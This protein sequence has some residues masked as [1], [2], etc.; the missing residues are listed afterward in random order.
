ME[1]KHIIIV[2]IIAIIL[3]VL[4]LTVIQDQAGVAVINTELNVSDSNNSS[5]TLNYMLASGR[6]FDVLD[7]EY[8]VYSEDDQVIG[9]G[10]TTLEKITSGGIPINETI[11]IQNST[12][13]PKK[14]KIAIFKEKLTNEQKLGN[15]S[16]A[17]EPI[18]E[19]T[20]NV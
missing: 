14:V 15:G 5:Y 11:N 2:F 12:L 17:I 3:I 7:C 13:T 9:Q 18:Y 20:I 19:E 4:S 16:Y 1:K 6:N 10:N 8:T